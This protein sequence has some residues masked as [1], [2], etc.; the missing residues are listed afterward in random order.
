MNNIPQIIFI[1]PY[2]NREKQIKFFTEHF[3]KTKKYYNWND[4]YAKLFFIHQSDKRE[5]NRGAMKNIGFLF[6]KNKYPNNY[7]NITLVFNDIDTF[8]ESPELINYETNVGNLK[9]FYGY[10]WALGGIFS[11]KAG[12]FEKTKGF[13][14]FWGW[15]LEDN[16]MNER[17]NN[18]IKIDRENFYNINDKKIIRLD[19]GVI[20]VK[21]NREASIYK[22]EKHILDDLTMIDDIEYNE[23]GYF[24]NVINFKLKRNYDNNEFENYDIRNGS[25]IKLKKG[26][27]RKNWSMFN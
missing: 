16:V 15:G 12:D 26:F 24:V 3:Y 20:R 13:P 27:Y 1:I 2:R 4:D 7:K 21:S 10:E 19:D 11:V 18:I 25:R 6:V 22:F 23:D 5:F 14:N 17:C 8:P 9:H